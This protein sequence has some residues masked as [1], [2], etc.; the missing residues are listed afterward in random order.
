MTWLLISYQCRPEQLDDLRELLENFGAVSVSYT[1]ASPEP[2]FD[3]DGTDRQCWDLNQVSALFSSDLDVDILTACVRNRLGPEN[4]SG[5]KI[6][7]LRDRDWTLEGKSAF[8]AMHFG[9]RLCVCPSWHDKPDDVPCVIEL[10]PGLAFGTGSHATTALC[11]EWLANQ[12]LSGR[13]LIDYGCG[14][15]ILAIAAAK[16]GA[17]EVVAVDMDQQAIHSTL[18]NAEKNHVSTQ[19]QCGSPGDFE[20]Y[21]ADILVA[22]ILLKPLQELSSRFS[23]LLYPGGQIVLSGILA[24]QL[25]ELIEHYRSWVDFE[26]P[27]FRDEWVM[28]SGTNQSTAG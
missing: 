1:G 11:L 16:L 17:P 13:K 26:D 21:R 22:N 25:T 15:G 9:K 5:C 27:V 10:D 4:V 3:D 12:D 14:S 6:E 20:L 7:S 28:I 24:S 19:I 18:E 23:S 2:V 8:Q